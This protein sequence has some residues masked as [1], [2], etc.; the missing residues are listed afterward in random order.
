MAP[1]GFFSGAT[2]FTISGGTFNEI[3]GNLNQTNVHHHSVQYNQVNGHLRRYNSPTN[4]NFGYAPPP[5]NRSITDPQ[6]PRRGAAR[7]NF[8]GVR[9]E[10]Y[11]IGR[12]SE[13][14]APIPPFRRVPGPGGSVPSPYETPYETNPFAPLPNRGPGMYPRG[15]HHP[16]QSGSG[17]GFRQP[18]DPWAYSPPPRPSPVSQTSYRDFRPVDDET[19]SD[20]ESLFSDEDGS[21]DEGDAPTTLPSKNLVTPE[22]PSNAPE[23]PSS[24]IVERSQ[25]F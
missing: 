22:G 20:G 9:M 8:S 4:G 7:G 24:N 1:G 18:R 19:M 16:P 11:S 17:N 6:P 21:D 2:N 15:Q 5:P 14:P 10:P 23:G 25:T 13:P 12:G 3:R